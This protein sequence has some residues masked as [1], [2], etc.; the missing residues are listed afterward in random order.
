[1][2][3]TPGDGRIWAV[4]ATFKA[5]FGPDGF[6]YVP[7]F[8]SDAPRNY[9]VKFA[10]RAVR[11]GGESVPFA[12]T[13]NATRDARRVTFDRGPVREIYDLDVDS[14]EQTFVVDSGLAGDV[15]V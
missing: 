1:D 5:S 6:V 15:D 4:G 2:F 12:A 8:G 10:L 14:V 11:V 9:P 3:D 13:A 7:F